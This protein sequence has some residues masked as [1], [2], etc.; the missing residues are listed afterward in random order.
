VSD[1]DADNELRK[2][3]LAMVQIFTFAIALCT[4]AIVYYSQ[5]NDNGSRT[6]ISD[7]SGGGDIVRAPQDPTG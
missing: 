7:K 3:L 2:H 5:E 6:E 4:L 1:E